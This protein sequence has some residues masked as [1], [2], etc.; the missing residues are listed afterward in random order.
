MGGDSGG[1]TSLEPKS[2]NTSNL[3]NANRAKTEISPPRRLNKVQTE[4]LEKDYAKLLENQ[5]KQEQMLKR[6]EF[7]R[8]QLQ[9]YESVKKQKERDLKQKRKEDAIKQKNR[10]D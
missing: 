3:R 1:L 8:K 10:E 4:K 2:S 9:D 5:A 6:Q 7:L